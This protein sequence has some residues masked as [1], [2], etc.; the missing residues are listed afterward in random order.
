M[1]FIIEIPAIKK[2]LEAKAGQ[3]ILRAALD[4]DIAYPY[5]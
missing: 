3:T 5:S 1:K 4:A 2:T